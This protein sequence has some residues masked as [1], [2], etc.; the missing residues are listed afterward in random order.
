MNCLRGTFNHNFHCRLS[1][2]WYVLD[3]CWHSFQL[4]SKRV[5]FINNNSLKIFACFFILRRI[6]PIS[7]L[8]EHKLNWITWKFLI[9]SNKTMTSCKNCAIFR[10]TILKILFYFIIFTIIN[11]SFEDELIFSQGSCLVEGNCINFS[12]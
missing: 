5:N 3:Y 6:S 1:L 7:F 9:D 10:F 8:E 11:K 4:R 12:T 2:C